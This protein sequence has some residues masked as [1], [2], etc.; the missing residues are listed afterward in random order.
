MKVIPGILKISCDSTLKLNNTSVWIERILNLRVRTGTLTRCCLSGFWDLCSRCCRCLLVSVGSRV[1]CLFPYSQMLSGQFLIEDAASPGLSLAL[2]EENLKQY[3]LRQSA[4]QK[5]SNRCQT[6]RDEKRSPI[7]KSL[8]CRDVQV[9]TPNAV[10]DDKLAPVARPPSTNR[11]GLIH[12]PSSES[13][14]WSSGRRPSG[15]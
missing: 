9:F 2:I 10:A 15:Q 3:S 12:N 14:G 8:T 11:N 7:C 5:R 1:A 6:D 13:D 4:K